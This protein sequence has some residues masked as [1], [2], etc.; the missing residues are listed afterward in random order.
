VCLSVYVTHHVDLSSAN[1][2]NS[3]PQI[4]SQM[5]NTT[6]CHQ[7]QVLKVTSQIIASECPDV[8]KYKWRLNLVWH[9]ML[10]SCTNL[11]TVGVKGL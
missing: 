2:S 10:H 4:N 1:Q 7:S 8:K 5:Q 9:R 6:K 3:T 11:A